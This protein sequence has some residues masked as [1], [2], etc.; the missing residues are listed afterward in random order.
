MKL[1]SPQDLAEVSPFSVKTIRQNAESFGFVKIGKKYVASE[2]MIY[3]ALEACAA[4]EKTPDFNI[5]NSSI[6]GRSYKSPL[7]ARIKEMQKYIRSNSG[8]T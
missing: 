4:S 6:A 5:S 2:E 1:L 7:A 8:S 3:R